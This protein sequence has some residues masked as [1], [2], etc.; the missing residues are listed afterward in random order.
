MKTWTEFFE[1]DVSMKDATHICL[2]NTAGKLLYFNR[3]NSQ[4]ANT[5][6]INTTGMFAVVD[7]NTK[8]SV[9]F[10]YRIRF[11]HDGRQFWMNADDFK[12]YFR[13]IKKNDRIGAKYNL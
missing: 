10:E 3:K 13:V 5:S 9:D 1:N 12:S 8:R 2:K 4:H 7:H 6:T 11:I